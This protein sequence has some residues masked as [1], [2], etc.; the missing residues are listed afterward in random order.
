LEKDKGMPHA[1]KIA[2]AGIAF[3][4]AGAFTPA[5]AHGRQYPLTRCGPDLAYLCPLRGQFADVPFHYDLA[6]HPGC[7]KTVVV[8]TPQGPRRRKSIVCGAPEREMIWWW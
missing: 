2:L 6:V 1:T 5:S 7:I 8:D 4:A 3:M